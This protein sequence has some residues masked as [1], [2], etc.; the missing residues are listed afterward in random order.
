MN[1]KFDRVMSR[2][3]LFLGGVVVTMVGLTVMSTIMAGKKHD[4][5]GLI[6]LKA[7]QDSV[8]QSENKEEV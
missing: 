6:I 8:G 5:E 2:I 1:D 7:L 4:I 3:G